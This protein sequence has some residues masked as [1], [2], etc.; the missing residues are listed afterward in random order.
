MYN[1]VK[2]LNFLD[3]MLYKKIKHFKLLY[4]IHKNML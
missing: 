3:R 1:I 4:Y 2:K